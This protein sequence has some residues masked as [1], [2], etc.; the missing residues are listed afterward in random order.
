[1]W[2]PRPGA[3]APSPAI[4][5]NNLRLIDKGTLKATVDIAIPKWR[6]SFRGCLWHVKNGKEW[7]NFPS[8]EWV[9]RA[10]TKKYTKLVEFSDRRTFDRF[11]VA[12]LAAVHAIAGGAP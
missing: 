2:G 1:M 11:Q 4:V 10:G 9:D 5:A 12:A 8:R 6:I 3:P 7:I